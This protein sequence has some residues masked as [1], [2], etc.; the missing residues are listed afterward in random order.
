MTYVNPNVSKALNSYTWQLL[1]TNLGYTDEDY[2][3]VSPIIPT[4]QQPEIMEIGKPFIV[5]GTS[6][7]QSDH[8]YALRAGA[9]AYNIY[10][11][12]V[13]DVNRIANL[14]AET[15]ERQDDAAA[16]VNYW[17]HQTDF[18]DISFGSI[19]TKMVQEAEPTDEEGGM[20]SALVIL[21]IKYTF[22]N[23][24]LVTRLELAP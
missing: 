8:L 1:K 4:Q 14:I 15:F 17:L 22:D 24:T 6:R 7:H 13:V 10:A 2:R 12:K 11:T 19:R 23:P 16:D 21:E 3:G 20:Y 5:F 18:S 9:V